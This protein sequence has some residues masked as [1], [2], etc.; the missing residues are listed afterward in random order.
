MDRPSRAVS[1]HSFVNRR[2]VQ[3]NTASSR[4]GEPALP[5]T[6]FFKTREK[7]RRILQIVAFKKALLVLN[8]EP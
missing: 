6:F 8:S 7:G 5:K 3:Q 4:H 2:V 1:S